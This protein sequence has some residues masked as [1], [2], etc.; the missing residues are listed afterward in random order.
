MAL[1]IRLKRVG[2]KNQPAYRIVVADSRAP[3][4]GTV[5]A[6][7]GHYSPRSRGAQFD[8][9]VEQA[10]AWIAKGATAS[11][12]VASVLKKAGCFPTGGVESVPAPRQA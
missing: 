9:N 12:T 2:R 8:V 5:V 10:R 7:I 6:M 1:K 3:R 11:E 4:D